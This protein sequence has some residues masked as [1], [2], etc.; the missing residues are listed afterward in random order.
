[1][2][3][4]RP[5]LP[6]VPPS[7]GSSAPGHCRLPPVPTLPGQAAPAVRTPRGLALSAAAGTTRGRPSVEAVPGA[8]APSRPR[9]PQGSVA[10][11]AQPPGQAQHVASTPHRGCTGPSPASRL[12]CRPRLPSLRHLTASHHSCLGSSPSAHPQKPPCRPRKVPAGGTEPAGFPAPSWHSSA[13]LGSIPKE[14]DLQ[15]TG[16]DGASSPTSRGGG[17]EG[18]PAWREPQ[19]PQRAAGP[20]SFSPEGK[21][22]QRGGGHVKCRAGAGLCKCVIFCSLWVCLH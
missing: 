2:L 12:R 5:P 11:S 14:R 3:Q 10:V 13:Q 1:M 6:G 19:R 9:C 21:L 4:W 16:S 8:L 7:P 20:K 18:P 17:S 22:R 15:V